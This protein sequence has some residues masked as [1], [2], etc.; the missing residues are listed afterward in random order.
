MGGKEDTTSDFK[1]EIELA[2][3][4]IRRY[5]L[6]FEGD[7]PR[8]FVLT[9]AGEMVIGRSSDA[10]L[11]LTSPAVSGKHARIRIEGQQVL[12]RDC[13]SRNGTR[14][15][16]ERVESPRSLTF[17]DV[18]SVG[19]VTIIYHSGQRGSDERRILAVEDFHNRCD[20]EIECSLR[21]RRPLGLMV[22]VPGP[23]RAA[24]RA[25]DEALLQRLRG[26]DLIATESS[27]DILVLA[28]EGSAIAV[29][30]LA[31]RL[32]EIASS[33][34]PEIRIGY[35]CCPTDACTSSELL[36]MARVAA[37]EARAGSVSPALSAARTID[38]GE[39]K[40]LVAD[41]AMARL[42]SVAQRLGESELPVLI[43]GETGT[44]KELAARTVHCFS[45][46][47]I[48]PF[49]PINCAAIKDTLLESEVF[50]HEKGAFT[51]AVR[52][53]PG[54]LERAEGGTL[55]LDEV[56]ELPLAAQAKLLRVLENK[57]FSRLGDTRERH[58]DVRLVAATN[59]NL[60]EE[61]GAGRFRQDLY[62]R[63]S[64]A[65]LVVPP[66][67]ERPRETPI[68]AQ[69]FLR[70]ACDVAKRPQKTLSDAALEALSKY[71]WP[72]NIREL[73]NLMEWV[74]ATV[75]AREIEPKHFENRIA[76]AP[77]PPPRRDT[78]P[79][80]AQRATLPPPQ[81]RPLDEEL[82]QLERHRIIEALAASDGNQTRAAELIGMP[83]RTFQLKLKRLGIGG[84]RPR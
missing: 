78:A 37:R 8:F 9:A 50:G 75:S 25:L 84:K 40:V 12:I 23:L 46:R 32:A 62:F 10:D 35:A 61:I 1:G 15:N 82:R 28:S 33:M 5:L 42:Y 76:A 73:K 64:G 21:Y 7:A 31:R 49:V 74:T 43:A 20:R 13:G 65:L 68:L 48:G 19:G 52:T 69:A 2:D 80:R 27:G 45:R 67:R 3:P 72:G 44:G 47:R 29:E 51:D 57:T 14:V 17:G 60:E 56:G 4:R 66:L 54:V 83:L 71:S 53:K 34:A 22:L 59:R 18:I 24:R 77:V 70:A 39:Y 26:V 41:P 79:P 58:A 63:L 81:F 11:R 36:A 55:F 16:G 30:A 38:L 6:V